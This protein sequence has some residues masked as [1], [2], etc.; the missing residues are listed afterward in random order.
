M[1]WM[2]CVLQARQKSGEDELG[3]PVYTWTDV[4]T[5]YARRTPWTNEQIA[6]EGRD[7]TRNEQRYAI[8]VPLAR[9]PDCQRAVLG[10]RVQ[11]ITKVEDLSPR[12]TGI[13]V[14]GYKE[15]AHG[16]QT[17]GARDRGS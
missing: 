11:E 5:T 2:P 8:P 17:A 15:A 1:I 4:L 6:L 7:V 3:N 14:K 10:G 12:Y 9:F 16:D 13:Q